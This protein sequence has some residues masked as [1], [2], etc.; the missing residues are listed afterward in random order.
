MKHIDPYSCYEQGNLT[1]AQVP[2]PGPP[3]A[4]QSIPVER[5]RKCSSSGSEKILRIFKETSNA[6]GG[7]QCLNR[8]E[9]GK[10][11]V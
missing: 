2:I 7:A 1:T 11:N 3:V 9:C 5:N 6:L 10:G 8:V 4:L